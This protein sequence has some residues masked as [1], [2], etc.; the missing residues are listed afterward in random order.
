MGDR[1]YP[2]PEECPKVA[3]RH[4]FGLR[5]DLGGDSL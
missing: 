3:V 2:L 4:L 5:F 1:E